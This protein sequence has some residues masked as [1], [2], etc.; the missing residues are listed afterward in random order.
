MSD[1]G[2]SGGG[3]RQRLRDYLL[4]DASDGDRRAIEQRFFEDDAFFDEILEA[5]DDLIDD[6][7]RGALPARFQAAVEERLLADAEGQRRVTVARALHAR[8]AAPLPAAAATPPISR[9]APAHRWMLAAAALAVAGIAATAW[10]AVDNARLRREIAQREQAAAPPAPEV[11]V[12]TPP[13]SPRAESVVAELRLVPRVLRSQTAPVA[14]RIAAGASIVRVDL[15]LEERDDGAVAVALERAGAGRVWF[16]AE[17]VERRDGARV[18]WLPASLLEPGDYEV[19]VWRG[20][21]SPA[22][23]LATYNVRIS[24]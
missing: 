20:V 6:Y 10:F 7:A 24:R 18:I 13:A 12:R 4:G 5:Q 22:T 3:D 21:E 2:H 15:P 8:A 16:Q 19:L 23:L 9:P 1:F 14:A 11:D 17:V